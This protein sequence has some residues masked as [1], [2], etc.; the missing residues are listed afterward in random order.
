MAEVKTEEAA[1][2]SLEEDNDT[3]ESVYTEPNGRF[4]S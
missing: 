4:M 2:T 1:N 3:E